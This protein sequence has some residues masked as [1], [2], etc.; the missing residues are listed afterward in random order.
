MSGESDG[1]GGR[2]RE[3]RVVVA[4]VEAAEEE[5]NGDG[6]DESDDKDDDGGEY[7]RFETIERRRVSAMARVDVRVHC[8][9]RENCL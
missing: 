2:W 9:V 8:F 7:A 3:R 5:T 6:D 1:I 4:A